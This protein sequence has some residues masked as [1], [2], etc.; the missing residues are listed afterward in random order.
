MSRQ[1]RQIQSGRMEGYPFTGFPPF[2]F[3]PGWRDEEC[4]SAVL[5]G[6][7][8]FLLHTHTQIY[9]WCIK[10][11][12]TN[13]FTSIKTLWSWQSVWA[14]NQQSV[15][16]QNIFTLP[17]VFFCHCGQ[18]TLVKYGDRVFCNAYSEVSQLCSP[19]PEQMTPMSQFFLL[20]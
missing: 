18:N 16:F 9:I 14:V 4:G 15:L 5:L 6:Y 12:N 19:N 7:S 10:P 8:N 20:N 11:T 3:G 1:E 17:F 13:I 2:P